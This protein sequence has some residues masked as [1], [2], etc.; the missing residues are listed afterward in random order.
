[1]IGPSRDRHRNEHQLTL[2]LWCFFGDERSPPRGL[3]FLTPAFF[4][5]L[6]ISQVDNLPEVWHTNP[7]IGKNSADPNLQDIGPSLF[8]GTDDSDLAFH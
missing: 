4:S 1:M 5:R 3:R 2:P 8:Q 6:P 7:C